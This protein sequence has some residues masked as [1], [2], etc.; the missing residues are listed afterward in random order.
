LLS[1]YLIEDEREILNTTELNGAWSY[2]HSMVF[3]FG[4]DPVLPLDCIVRIFSMS[5]LDLFCLFMGIP[6]LFW[7]FRGPV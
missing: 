5:L 3:S 1:N 7:S 6:S 2:G 4:F